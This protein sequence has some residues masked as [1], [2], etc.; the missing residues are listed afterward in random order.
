MSLL[1]IHT[2]KYLRLSDGHVASL[3]SDRL[4]GS[5]IPNV[6]ETTSHIF[7]FAILTI[8]TLDLDCFIIEIE[9]RLAIWD[10]RCN[11]YNNKISKA[12]AWGEMFGPSKARSSLKL[13]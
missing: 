11:D 10:V 12:K 1:Q 5:H 2:H 8:S 6:G 3:T 13:F 9:D 7:L 4:P